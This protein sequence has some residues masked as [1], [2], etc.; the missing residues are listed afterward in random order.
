MKLITSMIGR[1]DMKQ[2]NYEKIET[3]KVENIT[4]EDDNATVEFLSPLI[5]VLASMLKNDK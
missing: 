2:T 1:A 5:F 3:I 4:P